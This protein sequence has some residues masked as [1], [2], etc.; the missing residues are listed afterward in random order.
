[1]KLFPHQTKSLKLTKDYNRYA[2]IADSV[3]TEN[4][5]QVVE[6]TKGCKPV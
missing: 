5:Q 4:G 2:Y 6:D 3:Y 1:M